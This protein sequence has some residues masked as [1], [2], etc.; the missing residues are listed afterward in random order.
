MLFLTYLSGTLAAVFSGRLVRNNSLPRAMGFGIVLFMAGSLM[1]LHQQLPW[2]I[3]GLLINAIGFF[4]AHSLAAGW[5]A[6]QARSSR[7][8]ATSLYLVFYYAGATLGGFYLEPFWRWTGWSGVVAGSLLILSLSLSLALWLRRYE[9]T[10]CKV[11][12][13]EIDGE[14]LASTGIPLKSDA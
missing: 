4:L 5:V 9:R 13:A 7:G 3:A 12:T 10:D 8:S 11:I 1:T 2:I 6:G 14:S